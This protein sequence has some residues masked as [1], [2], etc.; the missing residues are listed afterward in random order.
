[1]V[2]TRTSKIKA[3]KFAFVS[4]FE[5][6][7]ETLS[8]NSI[9]M[10]LIDSQVLATIYFFTALGAENGLKVFNFNQVNHKRHGS[11]FSFFFGRGWKSSSLLRFSVFTRSCWYVKPGK[12]F[13]R[14]WLFFVP[15]EW[16]APWQRLQNN[17]AVY[18]IRT[19]F[20]FIDM[21]G[22]KFF[23]TI[24]RLDSKPPSCV[25]R[26]EVFLQNENPGFSDIVIH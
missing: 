20:N 2:F 25:R 6:S 14:V 8:S 17:T 4:N 26:S 16:K 21:R 22:E 11:F 10:M 24:F 9:L 12:S 23:L 1:M 18:S 15:F 5:K 3:T 7:W 19:F 13:L